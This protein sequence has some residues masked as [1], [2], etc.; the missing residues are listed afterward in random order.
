MPKEWQDL[1]RQLLVEA[2]RV[3]PSATGTLRPGLVPATIKKKLA[4]LPYQITPD[5][6]ALYKWVDGADGP[7]ELL[8]MKST[9]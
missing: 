3:N 6:A 5:A 9:H 1:F 7:F 4:E 8:P 2:K